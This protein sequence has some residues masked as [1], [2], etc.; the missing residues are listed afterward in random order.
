M[1]KTTDHELLR[2][3]LRYFE[4]ITDGE[5]G[6]NWENGDSLKYRGVAENVARRLRGQLRKALGVRPVKQ[7][8]FR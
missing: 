8:T 6:C 4:Q 1:T 7:T 5:E 3:C 2:A